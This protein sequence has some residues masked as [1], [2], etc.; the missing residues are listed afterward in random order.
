MATAPWYFY[1][2]ED[3]PKPV[4]YDA[5]GNPLTWKSKKG[6]VGFQPPKIEGKH[7]RKP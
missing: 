6:P 1:E 7:D 3:K 4:L 2:K 5:Q